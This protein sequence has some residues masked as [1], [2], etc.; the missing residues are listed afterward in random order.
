MKQDDDNEDHLDDATGENARYTKKEI[1]GVF[2]AFEDTPKDSNANWA[3][4]SLLTHSRHFTA[5]LP[6]ALHALEGEKQDSKDGHE[7]ADHATR[8]FRTSNLLARIYL[9]KN[10]HK[11]ANEAICE[12][13][14][15]A[16]KGQ[17][18]GKSPTIPAKLLRIGL[19]TRAK[20]EV[21]QGK[22]DDAIRSYEEARKAD[23]EN[24]MPG[25]NLKEE[26]H[27]YL[28]GKSDKEVIGLVK[29]WKPMERLA[30]M[31]W[32]FENDGYEEHEAFR[33]AAGRAGEETFMVEAYEEVIKLLDSLDAAAPIRYHLALAHWRVRNDADAAKALMNETLEA[34]SSGR[35]AAFTEED[36]ATTLVCAVLLMTHIIYEEYRATS[37]PKVKESLF[38]EMK[39]LTKKNLVLSVSPRRSELMHH[40]LTLAR[41]ARKMAS[42]TEFQDTLQS[43]FDVCYEGLVDGVGWNDLLNLATMAIVLGNLKGLDREARILVSAQFSRLDPGV[44]DNALSDDDDDDDNEDEDED[45]GDADDKREQEEAEGGN[46]D[47][48]ENPNNQKNVA[49]DD[50]DDGDLTAAWCTCDGECKPL[51]AWHSWTDMPAMYTCTV[52]SNVALCE[53]CYMKRI[54]YNNNTEDKDLNKSRVGSRYCGTNHTYIKGPIEGWKGIKDGVMRIET[55]A[56]E[57][58]GEKN[59]E[60][61]KF[62]DWLD[63]LKD[64]KWKK[65]WDEFWLHEE[66]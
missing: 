31:T 28:D 53:P 58:G 20:T 16:V 50:S 35:P 9:G 21:G 51:V 52:C 25:H 13:L 43:V 5:A 17:E 2:Q 15:S 18:E 7:D 33:R 49:E 46:D 41:M 57:G 39:G 62:R 11:T 47:R 30:W 22:I 44:N 1:I 55:Q 42:A 27:V 63:E 4:A 23:P 36:P 32:N 66:H 29:R 6:Y 12:G 38:V 54:D 59:V 3:V 65:A 40:Y 8:R 45:E 37:D 60:Q 26:F 24:P 64:V 14:A 34:S 48:K 10:D 19:L 56:G 61:V